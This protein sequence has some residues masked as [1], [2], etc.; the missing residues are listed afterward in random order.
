MLDA[1]ASHGEMYCGRKEHCQDQ[2]GGKRVVRIRFAWHSDS[3]SRCQ[4]SDRPRSGCG[5]T[6][7][8]RRLHVSEEAPPPPPRVVLFRVC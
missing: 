6:R 3:V 4:V 2:V 5:L 1:I 7:R 8:K